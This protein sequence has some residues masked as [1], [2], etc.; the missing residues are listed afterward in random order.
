M[1]IIQINVDSA[2]IAT[3]VQEEGCEEAGK[4]KFLSFNISSDRTTLDRFPPSLVAIAQ[5]VASGVGQALQTF[6][7]N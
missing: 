2:H 6:L 4:K 1:Y 3:P 5:P 7:K